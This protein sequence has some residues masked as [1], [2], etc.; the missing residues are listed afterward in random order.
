MKK[1]C[2]KANQKLSAIAGNSELRTPTQRKKEILLSM[3][4]LLIDLWYG[5]FLQRGAIKEL[6][7]YMRGHSG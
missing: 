1:I 4:N 7:K 3:H 6:I 2:E 5:C